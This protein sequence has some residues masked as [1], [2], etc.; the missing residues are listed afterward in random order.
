ME[1]M[2]S[3]D[4]IPH[5]GGLDDSPRGRVL[6]A[7]AHLFC[8]Q[9]YD[10]TTVRDLARVVGI[11]SGSLFHHFKT[12]E[13]ILYAV[14]EEAIRYNL[15]RMEEAVAAGHSPR[16]RLRGLI[17]AELESIN[18]D[19]GDAMSVL[20]YEWSSLSVDNQKPLL[21]MR[22]RYEALW[23]GVLAD[24]REQGLMSHDPFICRRLLGGAISWTRMWYKRNGPLS[25]D[26]LAEM[27]L[28]MA[29]GKS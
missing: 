24:A 25:L 1:A 14:M 15:A 23:E 26:A 2:Q 19:T 6:R 16:D 27:T 9:G 18:G 10:R 13:D 8:S 3:L 20:V 21:D 28:E 29:L 5:M 7:A 4:D 12:K 11:Q 22:A 17:R